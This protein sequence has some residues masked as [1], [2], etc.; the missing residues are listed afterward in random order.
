MRVCKDRMVRFK[1]KAPKESGKRKY[2][3]NIKKVQLSSYNS[4][5][6]YTYKA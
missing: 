2:L 6:K 5:L 3:F 1:I 4:H